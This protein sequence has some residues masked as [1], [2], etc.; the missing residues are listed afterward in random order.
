MSLKKFRP[1]DLLLNTMKAH[2]RC[3]FFIFDGKVYY[4]NI[5]EQSGAFS[6]NVRGVQPGYL[7]LYEY[8][9]DKGERDL[10]NQ[11]DNDFAALCKTSFVFHYKG[12]STF[13]VFDN[14]GV[15]SNDVDKWRQ[16][17]KRVG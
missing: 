2:P 16:E 6:A 17:R 3:E 1:E 15:I 10:D 13:E 9:I 7:S 5:P 4:N 8:N 11:P 14:Y 12:V